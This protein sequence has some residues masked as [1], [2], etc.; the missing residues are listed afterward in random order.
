MAGRDPNT[1]G[2]GGPQPADAPCI[3]RGK[4]QKSRVPEDIE[5]ALRELQT[6]WAGL[7]AGSPSAGPVR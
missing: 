2:P 6:V 3:D 1:L 4:G 7:S 5:A